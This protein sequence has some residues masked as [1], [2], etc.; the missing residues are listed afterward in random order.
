MTEGRA[1][2]RLFKSHE[3]FM[4]YAYFLYDLLPSGNHDICSRVAFLL[5][6]VDSKLSGQMLC[7]I[8]I[9]ACALKPVYNINPAIFYVKVWLCFAG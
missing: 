6:H 9:M 4:S 7:I 8:S 3:T 5:L 2:P 1:G